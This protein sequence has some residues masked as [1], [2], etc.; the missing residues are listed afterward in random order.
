[1]RDATSDGHIESVAVGNR[2]RKAT[3]RV[4]GAQILDLN[5]RS[6][7]PGDFAIELSLA[8]E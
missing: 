7:E 8:P 3:P 6:A 1:V 4:D 2:I 5:F